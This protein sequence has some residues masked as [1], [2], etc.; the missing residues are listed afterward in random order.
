[1]YRDALISSADGA[2]LG[3][4]SVAGPTTR[5]TN[6]RVGEGI[7]DRLFQAANV[8]EINVNHA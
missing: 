5:M 1:M 3:A 4:I 2:V 8:V 7:L 6:D